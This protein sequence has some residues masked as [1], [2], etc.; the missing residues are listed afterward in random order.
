MNNT[1]TFRSRM[2]YRKTLKTF[3]EEWPK[4]KS[5]IDA[6]RIIQLSNILSI[7][8]YFYSKI[9][10]TKFNWKKVTFSCCFSYPHS[11]CWQSRKFSWR[12]WQTLKNQF[13]CRHSGR[14]A[15]SQLWY[16]P[17][18]VLNLKIYPQGF[19]WSLLEIYCH[20][21]FCQIN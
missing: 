5:K 8:L 17:N 14:F 1:N 18:Q 4:W 7:T 2:A 16:R 21:Y 15:T 12:T 10:K 6:R 19:P 3:R 11:S 9:H 13:S 20:P